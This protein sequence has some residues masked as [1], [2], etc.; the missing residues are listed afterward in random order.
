MSIE[1]VARHL[2]LP[3]VVLTSLLVAYLG[4]ESQK[5]KKNGVE[6]SRAAGPIIVGMIVLLVAVAVAAKH[7]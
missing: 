3:T 7:F 1:A 2:I 4:F 5:R 6:P